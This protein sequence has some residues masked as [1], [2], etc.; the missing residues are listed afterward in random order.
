MDLFGRALEKSRFG[1]PLAERMRPRS[2]AEVVGQRHLLDSGRMLERAA[3][4]S[5]LPSMILYGPPGTGKTTLARIL[6]ERAGARFVGLSAVTS[7]VKEL[8]E[9]TLEAQ[10][11]LR[12]QRERTILFLDEIHRFNKSQQDALL[13]H[14]EAGTVI[15]IGA[16]WV[17]ERAVDEEAVVV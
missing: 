3:A 14:V 15:L 12:E 10:R 8:R 13:P 17:R 9:V 6:A 4:N 16:A 7:G 5:A 2:L 11:R 1:Q